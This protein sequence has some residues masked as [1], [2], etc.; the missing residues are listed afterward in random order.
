MNA[1]CWRRCLMVCAA[2]CS[3]YVLLTTVG[4]VGPSDWELPIH[5]DHEAAHSPL[6]EPRLGR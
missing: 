2:G 6:D 5:P 4:F 1:I 3:E